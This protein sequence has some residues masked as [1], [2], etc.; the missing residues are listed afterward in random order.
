MMQDV[1][2]P[3]R[4]DL[5]NATLLI[6]TVHHMAQYFRISTAASKSIWTFESYLGTPCE[7]KKPFYTIL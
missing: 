7:K 2:M 5:Y 1:P 4:G 3:V 6:A